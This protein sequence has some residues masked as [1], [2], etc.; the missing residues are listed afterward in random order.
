M[1]CWASLGLWTSDRFYAMADLRA[2]HGAVL[3]CNFPQAD[4]SKARQSV[5]LPSAP[6]EEARFR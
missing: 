3:R 1:I 6:S 4:V 2:G 5:V